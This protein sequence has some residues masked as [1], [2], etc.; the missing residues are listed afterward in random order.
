MTLPTPPPS[1]IPP[2]PLFQQLYRRH[3]AQS[4][5]WLR[6]WGVPDRDIADLAQNVWLR[7]YGSLPDYD[8]SRPFEPWL[9]VV[10]QRTAIDHFRRPSA[11]RE[12]LSL[13]G[14]LP[15]LDS[16][17]NVE[18]AV[19]ARTLFPLVLQNLSPERRAVFLMMEVEQFST[20]DT[21]Q[22]LGIPENTVSSRLS[23][24][25]DE[26]A[27]ALARIRAAER[28]KSGATVVLLP[29]FWFDW[30]KLVE[31]NSAVPEVPEEMANRVWQG[32][33]RGIQELERA[34]EMA[35]E[36]GLSPRPPT[37]G[38]E[39]APAARAA[40]GTAGPQRSAARR[41]VRPLGLFFAGAVLGGVLVY[42]LLRHPHGG[43]PVASLNSLEGTLP[44]GAATGLERPALAL[45]TCMA[46]P[47]SEVLVPSPARSESATPSTST[48]ASTGAAMPGASAI[49]DASTTTPLYAGMPRRAD[50]PSDAGAGRHAGASRDASATAKGRAMA[51]A[52][53][54]ATAEDGAKGRGAK[55]G[56]NASRS[57]DHRATAGSPAPRDLAV[58]RAL[59][60]RAQRAA[61]RGD[62]ATARSTL[63]QYDAEAPDAPFAVVRLQTVQRIESA[64]GRK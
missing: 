9:H 47:R 15:E 13:H 29:A 10:V 33:E 12:K 1:G 20:A 41:S 48:S 43:W 60:E 28:R 23:R 58:A 22:A 14:T 24:A 55:A 17:P 16:S 27:A 63:L 56:A 42:L 50:A 4:F 8:A 49:P 62:L 39:P 45:P 61:L 19:D 26:V 46:A 37:G 25:R 52:K 51:T 38:A 30:R 57:L 11:R 3:V 32:V 40:S 5:R 31:E 18:A 7:V 2:A 44:R 36:Q 53:D 21:A 59:I 64:A 35:T 54:S 34:R 6:H